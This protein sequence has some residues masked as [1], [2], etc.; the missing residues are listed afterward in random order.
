MMIVGLAVGV[1]A[2]E[3]IFRLRDDGAFPHLNAYVADEA[4]GVRLEPGFE[5]KIRLGTGPVTSFRINADGYRGDDWSA[6]SEDDILIVG[7]SQVF[8]LGVEA[9][10]TFGAKLAEATGRPVLNAGVPT[11]GPPEYR[12][13]ARE[14]LEERGAKTVVYVVNVGNDL[15]EAA[16]PN[17]ERHAVWDGWAVRKETAP[18]E[19]S[20]FPGR[21]WVYRNSHLAFALRKLLYEERHPDLNDAAFPSEGRWQDLVRQSDASRNERLARRE[22]AVVNAALRPTEITYLED[23]MLRAQ[24]HVDDLIYDELTGNDGNL[25]LL[26]RAARA[27][28]GDIVTTGPGE[29][30]APLGATAKLIR[31]G[32]AY[33]AKMEANL[34]KK[35]AELTDEARKESIRTTLAERDALAEKLKAL[36]AA[37]LTIARATSPLSQP[38][39]QMKALC[40]AHGA[41]LVVLVL[42]LDV[43][44]SETEWSKYDQDP[45]AMG[46]TRVLVRD[47]AS[48]ARS[49][50]VRAVDPTQPLADAEP[51]AFLQA[52][53]HLSP[54]GHEVVA[55]KVAA[56]LA[57]PPPQVRVPGLPKGRS[58]L[59]RLDDWRASK[60]LLVSGSDNAGCHTWL[61]QEWM[62]VRCYQKG[63]DAH[64][65]TGRYDPYIH[66]G[67]LGP[68][69]MGAQVVE[70]GGGETTAF[71]HDG[72]LTFVAP[73]ARGKRLV[74][75][76]HWEDHRRRLTVNWPDDQPVADEITIRKHDGAAKPTALPEAPKLCACH[77]RETGASHC[78]ELMGLPDEDCS[79][80]HGEDCRALLGCAAGDPLYPPTCEEGEVNAL[81][82]ERCYPTCS[83]ACE[84]E[85]VEWQGVSVCVGP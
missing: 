6:A 81:A 48:I 4:L 20:D 25:A 72:V 41:E 84:G 70:G 73:I 65:A 39:Q 16:R 80:T 17:P 51:G 46:T 82:R 53:L 36:R 83:D 7:D 60:Q 54:K 29:A 15:F 32:A 9:S 21:S 78:R 18:V 11:Y 12:A 27:T 37:P 34:R 33:R 49:M 22:A 61:Y 55:E 68:K 38:L 1:V 44:V 50:G 24:L 85:C 79:R 69:P 31:Q 3:G 45:I 35:A 19:T 57:Q 28:P 10:E 13:V 43:M 75:D 62:L 59:P 71:L 23:E 30:A 66:G 14:V 5:G 77:K 47:I 26:L 40:D 76:L 64:K 8:G 2:A 42:P 58:R 52:D 63:S 56:A 74:A 67:G